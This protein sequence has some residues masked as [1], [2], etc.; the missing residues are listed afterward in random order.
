MLGHSRRSGVGDKRDDNKAGH[1]ALSI[2]FFFLMF[3][4]IGSVRPVL[5]KIYL[6]HNHIHAPSP[7]PLA[8]TVAMQCAVRNNGNNRRSCS[9]VKD[10]TIHSFCKDNHS[11]VEI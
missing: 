5:V 6:K 3:V 1:L 4:F 11:L 10:A 2:T 9:I 7:L 8:P